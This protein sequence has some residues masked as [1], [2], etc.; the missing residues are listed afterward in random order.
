MRVFL[1]VLGL[2]SAVGFAARAEPC[3]AGT[4]LVWLLSDDGHLWNWHPQRMAFSDEGALACRV[5]QGSRPTAVALSAEGALWVAYSGGELGHVNPS[6]GECRVSKA[7]AEGILSLAAQPVQDGGG[8]VA[9]VAS[10]ERARTLARLEPATGAFTAP[11]PLTGDGPVAYGADGTLWRLSPGVVP[12]LWQMTADGQVRKR[13]ALVAL[14]GRPRASALVTMGSDPWLAIDHQGMTRFWRFDPGSG[15]VHLQ[16]GTPAKTFIAAASVPPCAVADERPCDTP[17]TITAPADGAVIAGWKP[18]EIFFDAPTT[19]LKVDGPGLSRLVPVQETKG[20]WRAQL[21]LPS[22][23]R[24][25]EFSL[26]P[27]DEEGRSCGPAVTVTRG[28]LALSA[29]VSAPDACVTGTA[30]EVEATLSQTGPDEVARAFLDSSRLS[31]HVQAQGRRVAMQRDDD[32]VWRGSLTELAAGTHELSVR[33]AS[34]GLVVERAV[35]LSVREPAAITVKPDVELGEVVAGTRWQDTC[36]SVPLTTSGLQGSRVRVTA[37]VPDGCVGTLLTSLDGTP[38]PLSEGVALAARPSMHLPVCLQ[39]AACAGAEERQAAL[40]FSPVGGG[41][42]ATATVRVGWKT[43][44]PTGWTCHRDTVRW[45]GSL[46]LFGLVFAGFVVPKRFAKTSVVRT[47]P[48]RGELAEAPERK[49]TTLRGGRRGWY[50]DARCGFDAD[51]VALPRGRE[52]VVYVESGSGEVRL[53]PGAAPLRIFNPRTHRLEP[54][55]RA[56]VEPGVVYEAGGL[57]LTFE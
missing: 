13:T 16:P 32:G 53:V 50:Q 52:A 46:L 29:S 54:V 7:R 12:E 4:R 8:L 36:V 10:E 18:F 20:R 38:Q 30:C 34:V 49:L 43:T 1:V 15:E 45:A 35:S 3:A 14:R 41:Q 47:A 27:A 25:A 5:A 40:T 21:S 17:S 44:N 2:L 57:W 22:A 6:S 55:D 23:E 31:A 56:V 9:V 42:V 26:R 51:G 28:R 19:R 39:V 11:V 24:I 48:S 33:W 37:E